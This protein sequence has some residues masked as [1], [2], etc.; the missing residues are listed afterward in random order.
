M[1]IP[2]VPFFISHRGCPHRCIFCDQE[3]IAGSNGTFPS[4]AE[5]RDK[6][7]AYRRT[8]GCREVEVAFYGGSFTSIPH[9]DQL[10]LLHPLQELLAAGEV[11]SIRISTRPDALDAAAAAFLHASGVATVELGVQS[12]DDAVLEQS[13]RGHCAADVEKA[14][15]CLKGEG[16][17][18]GLQLM[19]G[20]PGDSGEISVSSL[21]RVLD[22]QPD[23]LRIYPT[24]VVAGTPLSR[25]YAEGRYCPLTLEGAV[26]L[27]KILLHRA[28]LARVPVVRIGLQPT[29]DLS[30]R[31]AILA[32]PYH[33]AFRQP[34]ATARGTPRRSVL[35][36]N[37]R[38]SASIRQDG[39]RPNQGHEALIFGRINPH[40]PI[41]PD[42][43]VLVRRSDPSGRLDA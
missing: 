41:S 42:L 17:S 4:A 12:M 36:S 33:P 40:N 10:R 19:P 27:C 34:R 39:F 9:E 16:I 14:V 22:L 28:L 21:M 18:V 26:R 15:A 3:K 24:V 23:F 29:T 2:I 11:S 13:E 37:I 1:K 32:G 25:R 35:T 38:P 6:V 30:R 8:S 31:G 43:P 20:L 5:I 7:A